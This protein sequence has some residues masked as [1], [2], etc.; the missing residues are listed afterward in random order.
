MA[1]NALNGHKINGFDKVELAT[2]VGVYR[3]ITHQLRMNIVN[4]IKKEQ[5]IHVTQ[6]YKQ[7]RLEQSVTSSHLNI[8]REAGFVKALRVGKKIFYSVDKKRI[9]QVTSATQKYINGR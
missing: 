5:P 7:L 3:A 1:K 4:Y 9:K 2:T 6:I 8:L